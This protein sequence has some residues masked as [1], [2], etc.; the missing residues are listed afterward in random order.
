MR[1]AFVALLVAILLSLFPN[2][3]L[4]SEA[5]RASETTQH[6]VDL[7]G[8]ALAKEDRNRNVTLVYVKAG[9]H[10]T[11]NARRLAD[12]LDRIKDPN[13]IALVIGSEDTQTIA[14]I[15][16]EAFNEAKPDHL[17]GCI[18]VFVGAASDNKLVGDAVSKTGASY[19]FVEFTP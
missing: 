16:L 6:I 15:V 4:A 2:A 18:V 12:E 8:S 19:R 3:A 11:E 1:Y 14:K 9:A 10:V 17:V 13:G 5:T 7:G